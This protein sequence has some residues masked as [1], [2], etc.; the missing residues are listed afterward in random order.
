[1]PQ[2]TTPYMPFDLNSRINP[3]ASKQFTQNRAWAPS[4]DNNAQ[5]VQSGLDTFQS[6][7]QN[8]LGRPPTQEE[9]SG[10]A[11]KALFGAWNQP[12][13]LN[14]S[15]TTNLANNYIQQAFGPQM[16]EHQQQQQMGQLGKYQ[17]AIQDLIS[18]QTQA[19]SQ[20]LMNPNSPTYQGFAGQMNNMG[21]TPS[22]GAFQAGLGGVLGQSAANAQN[23]ALG[24]F[25]LPAIGG[26]FQTGQQPYQFALGNSNIGR[27]NDLEDF[28][29]QS[30]L[31]QKLAAQGAPSGLQ[32]AMGMASGGAQGAGGLMQGGAAAKTATSYVCMELIKRGLLCD[33]DMDDF[34][35]H[36]MPA[37][38]K[39]GRAFW[40]YAM[41]GWRLVDAVN[42]K[43]LDWKTFKPLLFDRVMEEPDPCKAVDLYADACHQLCISSDRSLWDMRVYRTS[44]LDSLKFL[45][46]LLTYKPFMEALYKCMRIKTLI[47]YDKPRCMVHR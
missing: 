31:A 18:K 43:G 28:S 6:T 4:G 14:F 24:Q 47:I 16:A 7:F 26:A 9:L 33:M 42:A 2:A 39:K 29:L 15:D 40:K 27:L 38:F 25:S 41:D 10:F 12:G 21:I 46:R 45:P 23:Q 3:E 44:F 20:D 11:S 22:S 5:Q 17:G 37:M 32:S 30:S 19:T 34:H 13:N 8:L 36:I 1:M 35:I